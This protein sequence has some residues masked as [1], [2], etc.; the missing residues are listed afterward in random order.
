M[1]RYQKDINEILTLLGAG[2]DPMQGLSMYQQALGAKRER[3][4]NREY[5]Q[6]RLVTD[7]LPT[8]QSGADFGQVKATLNTLADAYGVGEKGLKKVKGSVIDDF[9]GGDRQGDNV[10]ATEEGLWD[11]TDEEKATLLTQEMAAAG[12]GRA[13][14]RERIRGMML[15]NANPEQVE[16]VT[17]FLDT[18]INLAYQPTVA[19]GRNPHAVPATDSLLG[20][21]DTQER[22]YENPVPP[23][24]PEPTGGGFMDGFGSAITAT[25]GGLGELGSFLGDQME[26]LQK[27]RYPWEY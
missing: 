23:P 7:A 24:Q 1:G 11:Q 4:D 27:P 26:R 9:Y 21:F 17:P 25:A 10:F 2:L 20:Q 12:Y 3:A 6:Q 19:E 14:I 15:Q 16:Q 18:A 13:E 5:M 22:T 8:L